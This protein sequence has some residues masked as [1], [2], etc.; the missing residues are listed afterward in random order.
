MRLYV[1][2]PLLGIRVLTRSVL[3]PRHATPDDRRTDEDLL[4]V[5]VAISAAAKRFVT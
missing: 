5:A 2:H 4:L 1:L 3:C